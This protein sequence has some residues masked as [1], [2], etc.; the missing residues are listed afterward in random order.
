[1]AQP[2][3]SFLFLGDCLSC[4]CVCHFL[5]NGGGSASGADAGLRIAAVNPAAVPITVATFVISTSVA[6]GAIVTSMFHRS[7]HRRPFGFSFAL[8]VAACA[9]VIFVFSSALYVSDPYS[10]VA[11]S[12]SAS[13]SSRQNLS[14]LHHRCEHRRRCVHFSSVAIIA[15]AARPRHPNADVFGSIIS[16]S[17]QQP[18]PSPLSAPLSPSSLLSLASCSMGRRQADNNVTKRKFFGVGGGCNTKQQATY[19]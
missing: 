8:N 4:R 3:F 14:H 2:A 18:F 15:S 6:T 17:I 7:F 13:T 12:P 11:G 9:F 10:S 19:R 5:G 1:M 16:T